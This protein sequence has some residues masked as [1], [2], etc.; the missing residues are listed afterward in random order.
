VAHLIDA[1][2]LSLPIIVA[3]GVWVLSYLAPGTGSAMRGFPPDD[4]TP[5]LFVLPVVGAVLTLVLSFAYPVYF[6]AVRGATPGKQVL[7]LIVVTATGETPIGYQ[8]AVVRLMGY[9][10][11]G[12][13]LGI[14]F[15]LIA[16]SE[17]KRGLHDRL[18]DTC[19]VRRR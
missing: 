14:G 6:W 7:G 17:D 4:I 18:A 1:C 11:N 9:L 19:V 16:V 8:R 13:L 3:S 12:F 10:I 2:I 15:L 5:S